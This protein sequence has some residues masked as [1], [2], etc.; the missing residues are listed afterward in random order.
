MENKKVRD[1]FSLKNCA[2]WVFILLCI[3]EGIF[4]MKM[5]EMEFYFV[6]SNIGV[7][8]ASTWRVKI[9]QI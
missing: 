5:C 6:E 2:E 1:I 4:V 9:N 7:F 8:F 3:R